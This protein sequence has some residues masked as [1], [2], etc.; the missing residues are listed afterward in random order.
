MNARK[1]KI[2]D[3]IESVKDGEIDSST[4]LLGGTKKETEE[5]T[6]SDNTGSCSNST[7]GCDQSING[8]D[9]ENARGTCDHSK[10][11]GDCNN[12][13]PLPENG[14]CDKRKNG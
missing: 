7:V 12:A 5:V 9:C 10:N 3:F 13:A 11:G 4:I 1:Q 14:P 6:F 2:A 8:G